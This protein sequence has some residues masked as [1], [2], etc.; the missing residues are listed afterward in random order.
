MGIYFD[1]SGKPLS[2]IK[3]GAFVGKVQKA[4]KGI[5]FCAFPEIHTKEVFYLEIETKDG[6]MKIRIDPAHINMGLSC[7]PRADL[8]MGI[9]EEYLTGKIVGFYVS[10]EGE[11]YSIC[12]YLE[13]M[14]FYE[15]EHE[16]AL[17]AER[18]TLEAENT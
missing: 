3:E 5:E 17:K 12:H 14:D 10:L 9:T 8:G 13:T 6:L 1:K 4:T 2:L 7:L 18:N 16:R 11:K 15:E